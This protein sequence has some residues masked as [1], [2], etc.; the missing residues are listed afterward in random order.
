MCDSLESRGRG[1]SDEA[2]Q[3]LLRP[4]TSVLSGVSLAWL[5]LGNN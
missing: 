3:I 1:D 4:A 5:P 2:N